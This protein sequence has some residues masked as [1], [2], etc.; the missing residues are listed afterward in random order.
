MSDLKFMLAKDYVKGKDS[1]KGWL[2]SEKFDGYRACYCPKEKQFY[3]RQNK[4]FHAPE[5]FLDAMPS[6]LMDIF[7][8]IL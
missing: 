5:W 8:A 7:Q 6:M 3:S 4:L 1:V 2:L